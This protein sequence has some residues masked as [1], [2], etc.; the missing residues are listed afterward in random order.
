MLLIVVKCVSLL[1]DFKN[2]DFVPPSSERY[3]KH[4]CTLLQNPQSA[5]AQCHSAVD[6]DIYY[7]VQ[8]QFSVGLSFDEI[9]LGVQLSLSVFY[10]SAAMHLCQ[11]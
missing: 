4:W 8:R 5:F 9:L 7:K 3:A 2:K 11:L 6:T 1:V 10:S